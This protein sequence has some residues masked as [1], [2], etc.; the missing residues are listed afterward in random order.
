MTIRKRGKK[1]Y[2]L[3]KMFK[4]K[5]YSLTLD[6]KPTKAEA[7]KIMW[8]L[9]ENDAHNLGNDTF[10]AKA[11]AY[12]DSK[13]AILSAATIRGYRSMLNNMPYEFVNARISAV[14]R[15]RVQLLLNDLARR[16]SPKSVRN[17]SG[18]ISAVMK[19]VNPDWNNNV[20]LPQRKV[21]SFYVPEKEDVK[22][23]LT[24]AK[25]S[26]F[27]IALWLATFGLR[28][29]E[30]LAL[31]TSDLKDNVITVNKALV[32]DKNSK[33]VLKTTKTVESTRDVVITPY[34][35]DLIRK[36]PDGRVYTAAPGSI[37]YYLYKTQDELGIP[38][39]KLHYFRHFFASTARE[40]M[41][42]VYVEQMGGWKKGSTVMKKV[43]DYAQKKEAEKAKADFAR[44][45]D[46]LMSS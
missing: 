44:R 15:D 27:E 1:S 34:V 22:R 29:S 17:Y 39:F 46:G 7:E 33:M 36:L 10:K 9:I 31:E 25:G 18:F 4:G 11:T 23:I 13:D 28:R 21:E 40:T 3:E 37:L 43:Y 12:I 41:G 14:T 16:F 19:S 30:I 6:Y 5:R 8:D 42:D 20:A 26:R 45:L 2:Y 24:A 32:P 35:A 38:R